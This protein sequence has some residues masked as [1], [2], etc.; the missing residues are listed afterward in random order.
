MSDTTGG[1]AGSEGLLDSI[2]DATAAEGLGFVAAPRETPVLRRESAA[3][4]ALD[5]LERRAR[6]MQ[7]RILRDPRFVA[8]RARWT[9][10]HRLA[11]GAA[12]GGATIAVCHAT[13]REVVQDLGK[14]PSLDRTLV[15]RGVVEDALD[16]ERPAPIAALLVDAEWGGEPEEIDALQL[17]GGIGSVA[18]CPVL[19]QAGPRLLG[20]EGW[21][22]IPGERELT[23]RMDGPGRARWRSFRDSEEARFVALALPRARLAEPDPQRIWTDHAMGAAWLLAE[24]LRDGFD[25]EGWGIAPP[26]WQADGLDA[27][28]GGD[29]GPLA[30]RTDAASLA[31]L[32]LV[33]AQPRRGAPGAVVLPERPTVQAPRRF[34]RAAA[35][36]QAAARARLDHVMATGRF[37]QA[38]TILGK[39]LVR[40]GAGPDAVRRALDAWIAPYRTGAE[41]PL[42][43]AR[44]DLQ[45]AQRGEPPLLVAW[46]APRI[47]GQVAP[48]DGVAIDIF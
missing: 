11:Q 27:R 28:E 34:D 26:G 17:L 16:V 44:M 13:K 1:A 47:G 15:W 3:A 46:L 12:P 29:A 45:P 40:G 33:A 22:A 20:M 30:V 4:R 38:L 2:L 10:L 25:R 19:T 32:G 14:A 43:E 23:R 39:R 21:S 24:A 9:A 48:P 36:E 42:A 8:L 41:A 37:A 31:A 6:L 18:H 5:E 7:E 35:T